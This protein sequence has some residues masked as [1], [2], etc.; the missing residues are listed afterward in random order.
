MLGRISDGSIL[1]VL[2]R[3]WMKGKQIESELASVLS[4]SAVSFQKTSK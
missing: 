4:F 1:K 2:L 3:V